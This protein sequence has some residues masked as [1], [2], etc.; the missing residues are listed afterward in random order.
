[1]VVVVIFT[2]IYVLA[3]FSVYGFPPAP[4]T[5]IPLTISNILQFRIAVVFCV[6]IMTV[7]RITIVFKINVAAC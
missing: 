3:N 6:R 4:I 1:M 7:I 5:V 2:N